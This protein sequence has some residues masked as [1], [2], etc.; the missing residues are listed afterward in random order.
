VEPFVLRSGSQFR[1]D[2]P[3]ALDSERYTRDYNEIL[4]V[5]AAVSA[6]RTNEQTQIALFW[7]ASPTALGNPILRQAIIAEGLDLSATARVMALFY[8]AAADASVACWDAKYFYNF[9][10]PQPAIARASE[11]G[12]PATMADPTWLP[13]VP[14]PP[15]PEYPSGHATNSAAMSSSRRAQRMSASFATGRRSAKA[16]GK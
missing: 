8:L 2:P 11:D 6:T 1:P 9:W 13:L 15:H 16:C 10:R 5:G 3:P 12:N 7:R 4:A 14:T